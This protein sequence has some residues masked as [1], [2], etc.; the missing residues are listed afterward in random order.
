MKAK[1]SKCVAECKKCMTACKKCCAS[2]KHFSSASAW[3]EETSVECDISTMEWDHYL[4]SK[5]DPTHDG[6]G[7]TICD[8]WMNRTGD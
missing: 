4:N 8:A 7:N 3:D 2:C 5:N 1:H 6:P